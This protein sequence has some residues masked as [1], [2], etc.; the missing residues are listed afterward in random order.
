M[1]QILENPTD[2]LLQGPQSIKLHFPANFT[3]ICMTNLTSSDLH[4]KNLR[5]SGW[6]F[7][8][9]KN[10]ILILIEKKS[11]PK[12]NKWILPQNNYN[13][14]NTICHLKSH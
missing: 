2:V 12:T 8:P 11:I 13:T 4:K 10:R 6:K 9:L 5:Y 1:N 3:P 7:V 14:V